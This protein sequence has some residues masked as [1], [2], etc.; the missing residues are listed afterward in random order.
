MEVY[1]K[2]LDYESKTKMD[3]KVPMT[4][5]EWLDKRMYEK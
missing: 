3:G 1:K 5:S 4:F 2:Y